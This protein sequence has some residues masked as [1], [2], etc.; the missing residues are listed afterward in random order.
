MNGP[1]KL[2]SQLGFRLQYHRRCVFNLLKDGKCKSCPLFQ[3]KIPAELQE[4]TMIF[5]MERLHKRTNVCPRNKPYDLYFV[6]Y[7][8]FRKKNIG[9][10]NHPTRSQCVIRRFFNSSFCPDNVVG[11]E[12]YS[13]AHVSSGYK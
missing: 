11:L 13:S 8:G 9:P 1:K 5:I 7:E 6:E 12:A 3:T 2:L 10:G 4:R